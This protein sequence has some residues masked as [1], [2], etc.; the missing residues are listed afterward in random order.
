[1]IKVEPLIPATGLLSIA[2]GVIFKLYLNNVND[3]FTFILRMHRGK[4]RV[5]GYE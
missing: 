3:Q 1:M 2:C 4:T 5:D